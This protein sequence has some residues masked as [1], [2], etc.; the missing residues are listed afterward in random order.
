[1][2]SLPNRTLLLLALTAGWLLLCA[3]GGHRPGTLSPVALGMGDATVAAASGTAALVGNP[4]GL[5]H[6]KQHAMELGLGREPLNGTT[7]FYVAQADSS[8]PSGIAA[9]LTYAYHTGSEVNGI[10]RSG[11]DFRAGVALGMGGDAGRLFIGGS[12]RWMSLDFEQEGEDTRELTGWTGDLGV[13]LA[14]AGK[15]RLGVAWRNLTVLDADETPG[16]VAGGVAIVF[17]KVILAGEGSWGMETGGTAWRGGA[18]V[19]LG[20]VA[21]LRA[22][23][24]WDENRGKEGVAAQSLHLGLGWRHETVTIDGGIALDLDSPTTFIFGIAMTFH[25]PY[26]LG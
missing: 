3:F 10:T 25:L 24:S 19:V 12:V 15:V 21:Q 14:L 23:Y 18:A 16:R 8:S 5:A 1:M 2:P 13:S 22:G 20:D 4:A 6:V 17:D 11:S 9:G 26:T 7:S